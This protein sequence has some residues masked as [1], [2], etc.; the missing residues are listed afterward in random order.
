M[1]WNVL[2][3]RPPPNFSCQ[4]FYSYAQNL[5][6]KYP[7]TAGSEVYKFNEALGDRLYLTG[8]NVTYAE[9]GNSTQQLRSIYQYDVAKRAPFLARCDT[10]SARGYWHGDVVGE[11]VEYYMSVRAR[12]SQ[13]C[14]I[15]GRQSRQ[16]SMMR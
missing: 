6:S 13:D 1:G 10:V 4:Y 11:N 8:S 15:H 12:R 16:M 2:G 5:P 7:S 9:A 14:I 3:L